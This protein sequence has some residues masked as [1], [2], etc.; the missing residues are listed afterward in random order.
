MGSK[1][2]K[3]HLKDSYRDVTPNPFTLAD[4]LLCAL[5][6]VLLAIAWI[7]AFAAW[8]LHR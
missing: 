1:P 8:F 4:Y 5:A 3:V 7:P 6:Y 2:Y